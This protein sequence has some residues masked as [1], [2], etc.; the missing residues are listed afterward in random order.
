MQASELMT[1]DV[2]C[3]AMDDTLERAAQIMWDGDCGCVP[4]VD[5]D[6][7][8]LGMI[9]D[10][11]VCMA[12]LT[13]GRT[14][15][16]MFVESA[17]SKDVSCAAETDTIEACESVMRLMQVRRLPIIDR[18]GKL[19]GILSMNDLARHAH[20]TGKAPTTGLSGDTITETL[21]AICK[22]HGFNAAQPQS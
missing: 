6:R 10:R 1:G 20:R 15:D 13:Q 14:L 21:A 8:V 5:E 16:A 19:V 3:C 4:V 7:R 11:D 12:A 22:P 18:E 2:D 9:T 17:A